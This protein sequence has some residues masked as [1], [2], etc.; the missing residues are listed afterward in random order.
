MKQDRPAYIR[1]GK[2]GEP[3]VHKGA[4]EGFEIGK[5]I[6]ILE[7]VEV[8]LLSTG[9]MLPEAVEAGRLLAEAGI[10]TQVVSF[11]TIKPLDENCLRR[12][13]SDFRLVATLEEHSVV[14]GFGSA[15]AEWL[16]DHDAGPAPLLR[17]ATPDAFFKK[18]GEQ[19]YAREQ[20]GLAGH[21]IAHRVQGA[22]A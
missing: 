15:V 14:G 11:H 8:C 10:S 7:G 13:F 17:F 6:I 16:A 4:V 9:T 22:L 20:L 12:A 1:L 2:K 3:I 5:S 21:Q 19:E 18:S